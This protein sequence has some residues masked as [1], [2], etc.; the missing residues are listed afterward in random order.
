MVTRFPPEPSGYLH[1]G[2]A[3]A[4]LL[5]QFFAQK[6]KGRMLMRFDD[7]NPSKVRESPC[8]NALQ[9]C[10]LTSKPLMT[11]LVRSA[12]LH[13]TNV[14]ETLILYSSLG[15]GEASNPN[16]RSLM[17]PPPARSTYLHGIICSKPLPSYL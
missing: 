6:Y 14:L 7:T 1:I 2:H 5:N 15:I 17:T 16:P 12:F 13:A 9:S 4:A 11:A 3:K 8:G 10:L